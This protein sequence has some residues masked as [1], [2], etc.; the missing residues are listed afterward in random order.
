VRLINGREQAR[1]EQD[2][3]EQALR[4][5]GMTPSAEHRLQAALG[6]IADGT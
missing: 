2:E 5:L 4:S 1:I 3:A 6:R